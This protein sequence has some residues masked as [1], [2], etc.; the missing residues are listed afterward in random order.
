MSLRKMNFPKR[1]DPCPC[2][3]GHKFKKCCSPGSIERAHIQQAPSYIDYGEEPIR[4]V[5]TDEIGTKFFA[6]IDGRAI[7][8]QNKDDAYAVTR[9]EDFADQDPGE[10][11]VAGVGETKWAALQN[12]ISFVE[13]LDAETAIKLIRERMEHRRQEL[14]APADDVTE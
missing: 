12:K 13:V 11:N 1:N 2:G 9:L 6:D 7:V 5:I 10:I 4:W 8:F 14:E 3:S